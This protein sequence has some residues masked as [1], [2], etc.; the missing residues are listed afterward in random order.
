MSEKLSAFG[1]DQDWVGPLCKMIQNVLHTD[2]GQNGHPFTLSQVGREHR[3]TEL[4]FYF[5][6]NLVRPEDLNKMLEAHGVRSAQTGSIEAIKDLTFSPVRGMMRG[7]IDL[8]F[9]VRDRYFLIDWKTNFLGGQVK[10]YGP[11]ALE[12]AMAKG[13]YVLQ[14]LLYTVALHQYLKLRLPGYAYE[15]H[16]GGVYYLFVRGIDPRVGNRFGVF[17]DRPDARLIQHLSDRL[18]DKP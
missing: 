15:K 7:F 8:V 18:I 5:P 17:S 13:R 9:T 4:G 12:E 16:F 10:D 6:L 2:L 14:Y 1:F 11:Q 3:L